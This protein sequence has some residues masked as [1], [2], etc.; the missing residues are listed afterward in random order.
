[1]V[2]ATGAAP[3]PDQLPVELLT[4]LVNAILA[5]PVRINDRPVNIKTGY[6]E[7]LP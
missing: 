3:L 6:G 4:L 2:S 5:H 1:M 7:D